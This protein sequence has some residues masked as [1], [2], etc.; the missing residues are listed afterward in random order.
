VGFVIWSAFH[1]GRWWAWWTVLLGACGKCI[2]FALLS[3]GLLSDF[4]FKLSYMPPDG[5]AAA[6]CAGVALLLILPKTR[7]HFRAAAD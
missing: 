1:A 5:I 4:R 7:R 3:A 2:Y 6:I